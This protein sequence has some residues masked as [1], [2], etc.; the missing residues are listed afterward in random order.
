[1]KMLTDSPAAPETVVVPANWTTP[2]SFSM[3][4]PR[5]AELSTVR[6]LKSTVPALFNSSTPWLSLPGNF[7]PVR[8]TVPPPIAKTKAS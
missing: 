2:D 3:S 5:P 6:L 7:I 8:S 4:M 1:L